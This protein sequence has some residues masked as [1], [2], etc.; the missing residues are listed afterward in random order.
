MTEN[1]LK[2]TDSETDQSKKDQDKMT[3]P[4]KKESKNKLSLVAIAIGVV[5]IGLS[6]WSAYKQHLAEQILSPIAEQISSINNNQ[7]SLNLKVTEQNSLAQSLPLIEKKIADQDKI[8]HTLSSTVNDAQT[9]VTQQNDRLVSFGKQINRIGSTTKEDWK[10]AESEYLI[11]LA[12]QRLLMESDIV[13]AE[14]LLSSADLILSEMADPILF[15]TRKAI[16]KDIQSL[17][18][19]TSF[20]T[21][22]LYLQLDALAA[23]ISQLPQR[24]PSKEWLRN[25]EPSNP[26]ENNSQERTFQ[27]TLSELWASVKSL[28]VI[29]YN[30]KPIKA[31]L[32]AADYQELVSSIQIQISVAQLALLKKQSTIYQTSL[33]HVVEA[34][35]THFDLKAKPVIAFMTS[36]TS[37]QQINPEPELP[38]PRG[39]LAAIKKLMSEWK[40]ITNESSK[41]DELVD[42]TQEDNVNHTNIESMPLKDIENTTEDNQSPKLEQ[43]TLEAPIEKSNAEEVSA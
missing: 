2:T 4:Q 35:S 37:L 34:V 40:S 1:A 42:N 29:N 3:Q 39:S 41:P 11:R 21:E 16:A 33:K 7:S 8:I 13:G 12:N 32:P 9:Q 30:H 25:N 22:G 28:V 17:K 18:A 23:Q 31:L 20:D 36:I 43:E 26:A 10:L 19:T 15:E 24:E 14:N 5:A 38:L 6:G 27:S